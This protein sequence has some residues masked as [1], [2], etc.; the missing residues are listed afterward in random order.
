MATADGDL[1]YGLSLTGLPTGLPPHLKVASPALCGL[2]LRRVQKLISNAGL[3]GLLLLPGVDGRY[4][5]G[6]HQVMNTYW[7]CH[8]GSIPPLLLPSV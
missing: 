7:P 6:S 3:D 1:M 5:T 2:R 8:F 4:N